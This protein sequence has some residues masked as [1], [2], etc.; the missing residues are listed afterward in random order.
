MRLIFVN[1]VLYLLLSACGQEADSSPEQQV[2]SVISNIEQAAEERS[3]SG[4]MEHISEAYRDH[5]E[6]GKDDLRRLMQFQFIRNQKISIFSRIQSL[7]VD[8]DVATVE[9]S[10][11]MAAR[12]IDLSEEQNRLRANLHSFSLVLKRHDDDWLIDSA[13]W[14]RGWN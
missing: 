13:S 10:A 6:Y 3:L 4:V 2:R 8:G 11:A 7:N 14:S 12:E 5:Q 9:L 1:V